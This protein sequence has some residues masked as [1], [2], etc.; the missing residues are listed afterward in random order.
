MPTAARGNVGADVLVVGGGHRL[1]RPSPARAEP[2]LDVVVVERDICGGGPS[3]R[4]GGFC[5]GLW[6]LEELVAR[7]GEERAVELLEASLASVAEIGAWCERHG[8]DAWYTRGG[9]LGL[10][11]SPT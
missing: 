3:G 6:D 10:A 9:D 7:F 2:G 4:N 11:T 1:D 8:V 5:G